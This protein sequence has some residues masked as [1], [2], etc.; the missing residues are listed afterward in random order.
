LS[1]FPGRGT[2]VNVVL[3]LMIHDI[4]I[5]LSLVDSKVE[6]IDAMGIPILT[7]HSDIANAWIEFENGCRANLTVSRV[8]KEKTRRTLIFLPNGT[9]SIDYLAQNA[10]FTKKGVQPGKDGTPEIITEEMPVTRVDSLE[11]EI[12]AFLQSVRDRKRARVSGRDGKRA[13]EVALRIV[14][15]I[16]ENG[17][18]KA[19]FPVV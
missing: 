3:D 16:D 10:S 7:P 15:K 11:A 6:K 18:R 5:L 8:S 1:P 12:L 9:L 13:L 4:D 17:I 2:D 14:R 19:D